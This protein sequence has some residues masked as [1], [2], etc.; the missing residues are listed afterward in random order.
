MKSE[1]LVVV[2]SLSTL[3]LCAELSSAE[4]VAGTDKVSSPSSNTAAWSEDYAAFCDYLKRGGT[5][6]AGMPIHWTVP[7]E[8]IVEPKDQWTYEVVDVTSQPW[9]DVQVQRP[10]GLRF[11]LQPVQMPSGRGEVW[12]T[13]PDE[14]LQ[15]WTSSAKGQTVRIEGVVTTALVLRKRIHPDG[16]KSTPPTQFVW[17]VKMSAPL[18]AVSVNPPAA[19]AETLADHSGDTAPASQP[20]PQ[21]ASQTVDSPPEQTPVSAAPSA[22]PSPERIE[23]MSA[24]GALQRYLGICPACRG[25]GSLGLGATRRPCEECSGAGRTVRMPSGLDQRT[26]TLAH[27]L[28]AY[29]DLHNKVIAY[30]D[31][32]QADKQLRLIV[33]TVGKSA[34][35]ALRA[36]TIRRELEHAA[37]ST[38]LD[39]PSPVGKV[40]AFYGKVSSAPPTDEPPSM[41]ETGIG[42]FLVYQIFVQDPYAADSSRVASVFLR[43][44]RSSD[45]RPG[46]NHF[47][48]GTVVQKLEYP[49]ASG[50]T[51]EGCVVTEFKDLNTILQ[52]E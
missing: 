49:T 32:V 29:A 44:S 39:D 46:S 20:V 4:S 41:S 24:R 50:K 26:S 34:V 11:G 21:Q 52:E 16:S 25:N 31:V 37:V 2:L 23:I 9:K 1:L 5:T 33:S 28:E 17:I 10:R 30:R 40:V 51:R 35:G 6:K 13:C 12:F 48:I 43:G 15:Q 19:A 8:G 14:E 45:L 22:P 42:G 18:P 47:V 36:A 27:Y 38:L 7:F 3:G